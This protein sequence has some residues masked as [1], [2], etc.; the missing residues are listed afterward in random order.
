MQST[1]KGQIFVLVQSGGWSQHGIPSEAAIAG[2]FDPIMADAADEPP[3]TTRLKTARIVSNREK[4]SQSAIRDSFT[5]ASLR[6]ADSVQM[7]DRAPSFKW[8]CAAL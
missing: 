8:P 5:S 6:T 3:T 1:A 7:I 2:P 4:A